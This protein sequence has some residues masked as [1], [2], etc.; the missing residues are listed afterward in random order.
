MYA[1]NSERNLV[2]GNGYINFGC[3][4]SM[5][6]CTD[7]NNGRR[8]GT[9]K[10]FCNFL[11]IIQ[12]L[13]I[14]HCVTGYPVEPQDLPIKTRHLDAYMAFITLTD[15]VWRARPLGRQHIAD[16]VRMLCITRAIDHA[17]L[18]AEPGL[19]ANLPVNS[20]L[21]FG[22][23][24]AESLMEMARYG[25]V[26]MVNSFALAGAMAPVT[27]AG[28]LAQQ[29]AEVL[30]G[31]TLAQIVRPG[32]PS[33]YAGH[34][35]IADMRSG[36]PTFGT[37]N[38]YKG[39]FASAQLARRYG[40]PYRT[41]NSCTSN[42]VDAQAAYESQMAIW[43]GVMCHA[44]IM[45]HAIGWL[46]AG[47]TSSFEKMIIDAEL[48]Q[49]MSEF[50]RPIEVNDDTLAFDAIRTVGPGGHFFGC[51]HTLAHYETAGYEPMVSDWKSF[52]AWQ[53]SG[54]LSA[55]QRA[56]ATWKQILAQYTQP[57]IDP[58]V[59]EELK[60]FVTNCKAK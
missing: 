51:D 8:P 48:L 7:L 45:H 57:A 39:T 11:R 6:Y 28:A 36:G 35:P 42:I 52:D 47:L 56:N 27:L 14:I 24:I 60:A 17:Q 9:Y 43:A 25:Q 40:L 22:S 29:N 50:L 49:M 19:I 13:N 54:G 30:A 44:S 41:S 38:W 33:V 46:E 10:D 55:T 12:N 20:P 59:E 31:I 4:G 34:T 1:R 58:A 37:P 5:P 16:A 3:A 26:V 15:R 21:R 32:C 23:E 2:F 53:E 18:E